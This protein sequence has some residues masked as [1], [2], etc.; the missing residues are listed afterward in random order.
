MIKQR[1]FTLIEILI[2]LVLGLIIIGATLTLY[3]TSVRSSSE[4]IQASRLNH[5]LESAMS[6]MMNDIK[7]AGYWGGA[8]IDSDARNN[9][10][11]AITGTITNISIRDLAAPTTTVD[12]GN[13]LLY[14]Y[15]ADNNGTVD[16]N[17][18]YGF[19][20]NNAS[21]DIRTTGT[22]TNSCTDGNWEE[23]VF[24]DQ[25]NITTLQFS[26]LPMNGMIATTRCLDY[27]SNPTADFD[28]T[29]INAFTDGDI[30]AGNQIAEKRTINI[31][32]SG[33]LDSDAIVSKT[34]T[35]S[36]QVRN[37]RLQ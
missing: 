32:I 30:T 21:I 8:V 24:G 25:L 3:I 36:V 18:Y 28:K 14:S 35:G 19:R 7:R 6:L 16:T 2:S 20:L 4:I 5:D 12:P 31:T 9:P 15:D 13:C 37:D 10:F 29:C 27:S 26:W 34:L 23:F 11:T 1:G 33:S 22:T 17:E